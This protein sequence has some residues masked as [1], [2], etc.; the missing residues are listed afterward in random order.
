MY[1]TTLISCK[2]LYKKYPV[3]LPHYKWVDC[4]LPVQVFGLNSLDYHNVT[5]SMCGM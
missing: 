4:C 2:Y 3:D 5:W 1:L